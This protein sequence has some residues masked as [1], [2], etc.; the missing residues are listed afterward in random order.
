MDFGDQRIHE[1][2]WRGYALGAG[3]KH[4]ER[5]VGAL[6]QDQGGQL[7]WLRVRL[8]GQ[9]VLRMVRRLSSQD[10]RSQ[11]IIGAG[12]EESRPIGRPR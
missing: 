10:E 11:G 2:L 6:E 7:V 9:R 4:R 3:G 12:G 1:W 8:V 5:G